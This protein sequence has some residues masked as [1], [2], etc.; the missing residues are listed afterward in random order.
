M[1]IDFADT[2]AAYQVKLYFAQYQFLLL[3]A[4]KQGKESN[5]K[6]ELISYLISFVIYHIR[7]N[8][9]SISNPIATRC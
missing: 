8:K 2:H 7:M 1:R 9:Q 6:R 3:I 4:S 5:I